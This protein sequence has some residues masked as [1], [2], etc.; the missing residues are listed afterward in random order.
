MEKMSK[1]K[2][3]QTVLLAKLAVTTEPFRLQPSDPLTSSNPDKE[4]SKVSR[5]RELLSKVNKEREAVAPA[6]I[7]EDCHLPRQP[8]LQ[9]PPGCPRNP[10][11]QETPEIM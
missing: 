3:H 2:F 9:G 4:L 11:A 1:S 6:P 5:D 10:G 8:G 7:C